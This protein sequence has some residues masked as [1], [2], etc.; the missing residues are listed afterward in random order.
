MFQALIELMTKSQVFKTT[1][2]SH[3]L[4]FLIE[5]ISENQALKIGWEDRM[6]QAL[7]EV[8]TEGKLWRRAGHATR[9]MH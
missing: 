7:I 9:S 1:W 6:F 8:M 2:L 4:K 5:S 3:V